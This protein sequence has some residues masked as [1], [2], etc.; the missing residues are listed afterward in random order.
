ME[1]WRNGPAILVTEPG[2][3][4]VSVDGEC[5]EPTASEE[6]VVEVYASPE[7]P[8]VADS[9]IPAPASTNLS[10]DG[11]ELH[12]YDSETS[13]TP[14]FIGNAFE[15]PVLDNTTTYWVE[16]VINHG[17]E[18]A[19]GGS[20]AQDE[21]QYHNNSNYWLRFDAYEAIVIESVKVFANS[22]GDRTVAVIDGAGNVLD[23][24]T[25]N[26]PE[27]ESVIQLGP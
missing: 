18:V 19:T 20:S 2:T 26:V 1:Q 13:E 21:G 22:E 9:S 17:L 16:D 10:F 6:V 14:L 12:W 25:V 23:E 27:G 3:Y 7:T 5:A 8:T 11:N 4:S 24:V 15:T